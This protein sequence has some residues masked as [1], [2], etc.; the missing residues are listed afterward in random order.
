MLPLNACQEVSQAK[1]LDVGDAERNDCFFQFDRD[2]QFSLHV[3]GLVAPSDAADY[4]DWPPEGALQ[5]RAGKLH[6]YWVVAHQGTDPDFAG[7]RAF[8]SVHY[9]TPL[10]AVQ[11]LYPAID[12]EYSS[13]R[14]LT[15]AVAGREHVD[16]AAR[17]R[18][19]LIEAK[20]KFCPA[21]ALELLACSAR[22]KA[23]R[24]TAA[25]QPQIAEGDALRLSRARKLQFFLTQPFFTAGS[26]TGRPGC[27]VDLPDTLDGCRQILDGETDDLPAEAFRYAG[28]LAHVRE[29]AGR[30]RSRE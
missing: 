20:R 16:L 22:G 5:D 30:D 29:L 21:S 27:S 28:T 26:D 3:F 13:S 17:V 7:L 12:P 10:L 8:D 24:V 6:T 2:L 9:C 15:E 1:W 4:R 11:G 18:E 14:L 23:S 19:L 25:F